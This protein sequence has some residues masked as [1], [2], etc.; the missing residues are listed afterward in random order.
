MKQARELVN[1]LK[2]IVDPGESYYRGKVVTVDKGNAVCDVEVN[3][4]ELGDVRLQA[5]IKQQ[6][7]GF[8]IFPVVGSWV[9]I[10]RLDKQGS[11][12]VSMFSEVE[13]VTVEVDNTVFDVKD[14]IMMKRGADTI[15]EVLT[16]MIHATKKTFVIN[17]TNPIY[18]ELVQA[19]NKVN[20]I[21]K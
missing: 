3:E 7:K 6:Q 8:K 4:M 17:G 21:F 5:T 18:T 19:Q 20:N 9:I 12:F 1:V 16:L 2:N 14:G 13:Q 11:F 10:E 15:K